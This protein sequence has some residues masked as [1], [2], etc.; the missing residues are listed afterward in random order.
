[1]LPHFEPQRDQTAS[2]VIHP[3][4]KEA[5]GKGR[6]FAVLLDE[7][8]FALVE[9]LASVKKQLGNA[10]RLHKGISS[11]KGEGGKAGLR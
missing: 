11:A 4:A 7:H 5:V 3:L 6:E 9:L 1:M 10:L 8:R 2:E